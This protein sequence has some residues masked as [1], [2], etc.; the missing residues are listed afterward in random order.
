MNASRYRSVVHAFPD[1]SARQG[2]FRAAVSLHSHTLH[3]RESLAFIQRAASKVPGGTFALR[4]LA[5]YHRRA[6]GTELDMNRG[7]WTPPLGAREAWLVE[8]RQ[9]EDELCLKPLISLTDHDNINAPLQLRVLSEVRDVPI[10]VEWTAPYRETFF[11]LGIHNLPET[12]CNDLMNRMLQ[13]TQSRCSAQMTALLR[14]LSADPQVL[15][16]FNH[17]LWDES[18]VG[19]ALHRLLAMEFLEAHQECIHALELNGLRPKRENKMVARWAKECGLPLIS[20]G[21]RHGREPN[22]CLNL[23]SASTFDQFAG[24]VRDGWSHI[25]L[26]PRYNEPHALRVTHGVYDILRHDEHHSMGWRRWS[27]RVF[28]QFAGGAVRSFT[29]IWGVQGPLLVRYLVELIGLLGH[30]HIRGVLRA[31]SRRGEV[32]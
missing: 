12:S 28:Y 27:D 3:S 9:I 21:D 14:E 16:V 19:P 17:P 13:L 4:Q 5:R 24:E 18:G 23:T 26:L 11:H 22:A 10:S 32:L 30:S 20:G 8:K 15:I 2:A 25:V 29:D 31:S 1:A 7:W 6:H